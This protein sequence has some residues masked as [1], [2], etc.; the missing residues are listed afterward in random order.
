MI[1]IYETY[2]CPHNILKLADI[3]PIVYFTTNMKRNYLQ[4]KMLHTS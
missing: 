3:L 1:T 4:I 2:N